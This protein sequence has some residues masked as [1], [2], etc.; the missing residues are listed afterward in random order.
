M[1]SKPCILVINDTQ[2]IL[3]LFNDVPTEEGYA[4]APYG[5][6]INDMA[7]VERVHP[8]RIIVDWLFTEERAG[9]QFIQNSTCVGRRR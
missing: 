7:E 5:S 8:D 4:V 1:A 9:W 2:D 3:A 6:A